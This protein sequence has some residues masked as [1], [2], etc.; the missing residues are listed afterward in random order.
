MNHKTDEIRTFWDIKMNFS[1]KY[2]Y[3]CPNLAGLIRKILILCLLLYLDS[4]EA[5][6]HGRKPLF[7][8]WRPW[9]AGTHSGKIIVGNFI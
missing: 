1:W 5:F 9:I 4:S 2:P 8:T 7:K 3:I 6:Y